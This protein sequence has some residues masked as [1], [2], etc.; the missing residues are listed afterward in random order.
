M[1]KKII[2]IF[3]TIIPIILFI[4]LFEGLGFLNA[5]IVY[6]TGF[7]IWFLW[8]LYINRDMFINSIRGAE[9]KIWGKPLEPDFWDKGELKKV[10]VK[11]VLKAPKEIKGG[12]GKNVKQK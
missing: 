10:K 3:K 9:A 8:R 5:T 11:L 7:L 2:K 1:K 4:I 12:K 6:L